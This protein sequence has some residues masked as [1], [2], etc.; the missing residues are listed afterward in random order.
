LPDDFV[1]DDGMRAWARTE[2][3]HVNP[4]DEFK[5]FADYWRAK[6]GKD[7]CKLDWLA[8]WRN[9]MRNAEDRQKQR[10]RASPNGHPPPRG[11]AAA[12]LSGEVYGKGK[13]R[14]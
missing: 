12:D 13:T 8:T 11:G 3:P 1:V 14:I 10:S 2:C 7:A 5:R 6:P 9:W 4:D